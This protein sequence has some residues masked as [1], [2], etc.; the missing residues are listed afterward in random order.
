MRFV[1][2]ACAAISWPTLASDQKMQIP[3]YTDEEFAHWSELE[4]LCLQHTLSYDKRPDTDTPQF[5]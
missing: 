5:K 4:A 1:A 2:V 3:V